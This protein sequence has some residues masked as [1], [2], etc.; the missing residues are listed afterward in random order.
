MVVAADGSSVLFKDGIAKVVNLAKLKVAT[1]IIVKIIED[2]PDFVE[3][4]ADVAKAEDFVRVSVSF[5]L[6][7]PFVSNL[8]ILHVWGSVGIC[9]ICHWSICCTIRGWIVVVGII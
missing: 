9:S 6:K 3:N 4:A 5:F 8:H 7:N 1:S 2:V